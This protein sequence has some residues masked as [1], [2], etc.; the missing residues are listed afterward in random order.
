MNL[1]LLLAFLILIGAAY[2]GA[3]FFV[4][5][6]FSGGNVGRVKQFQGRFGHKYT[7]SYHSLYLRLKARP[8]HQPDE[9]E[10]L[11]IGKILWAEGQKLR[12]DIILP[13]FQLEDET[14]RVFFAIAHGQ[15]AGRN[16]ILSLRNSGSRWWP[17]QELSRIIDLESAN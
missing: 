17:K 3:L 16:T 15:S 10:G 2:G 1:W 14:G 13:A 12:K 4:R 8:G 9:V 5:Q 6:D 11:E 7:L